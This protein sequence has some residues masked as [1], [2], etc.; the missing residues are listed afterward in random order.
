MNKIFIATIAFLTIVG[1]SGCNKSV[2]GHEYVDLGLSVNWATCN[3]GSNYPADFGDYLAWGETDSK[4]KPLSD[5]G[6]LTF[7]DAASRAW[8]NGWRL[9][10]KEEIM[11]LIEKCEWK[12]IARNGVE[13]LLATS[14]VNGES[15]FFPMKCK[16]PIEL[17]QKDLGRYWSCTPGDVYGDAYC[18]NLNGDSANIIQDVCDYLYH[19]R[20]VISRSADE[21]MNNHEDDVNSQLKAYIPNINGHEYVDLGLPSGLKWAT[22]NVGSSSPKYAG[23][24][25][26]WGETQPK[27]S[28]DKSNSVTHDKMVNDFA[29]DAAY[30]AARANWGGTWRLPTVHEINELMEECNWWWVDEDG[31][32]GYEVKSKSNGESVFIPFTGYKW[33]SD[34]N[35]VNSYCRY[36]CSTPMVGGDASLAYSL[37]CDNRY[38]E[39]V[40]NYRY[41]GFNVRAVSE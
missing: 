23:D 7:Y 30:D 15:I 34:Y 5:D 9:P 26:A 25:F 18:L 2:G 22:C 38:I 24:Y 40:C 20:P 41:Y 3:V 31:F 11:E 32:R 8:G 19:I 4:S 14:K 28:H 36:W 17:E 6:T 10:S 13:G 33:G 29:G 27:G 1:L 39:S 21:N 37:S 35:G 12:S 16:E